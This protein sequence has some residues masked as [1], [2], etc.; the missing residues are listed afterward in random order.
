MSFI[1]RLR[2]LVGRDRTARRR[3]ERDAPAHF[4]N[5]GADETGGGSDVDSMDRNSTTGTTQNDEFVGRAG[6][7]E[8][9]DVGL[10]GGEAR[11]GHRAEGRTGAARDE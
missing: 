9:G 7:D 6:G 2:S 5:A 3:G 4:A 1:E 10:S 11:T 8:T